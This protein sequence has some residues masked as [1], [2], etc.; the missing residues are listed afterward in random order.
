MFLYQTLIRLCGDYSTPF[1][2]LASPSILRLFDLIHNTSIR[3]IASGEFRTS[4]ISSIYTEVVK[5]FFYIRRIFSISGFFY[6]QCS[7]SRTLSLK[8]SISHLTS[9]VPNYIQIPLFSNNSQYITKSFSLISSLFNQTPSNKLPTRNI[10]TNVT[11]L[12]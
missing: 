12:L 9:F 1:Y 5:S 2:N 11:F 6:Q 8:F 7:Y 3:I 10:S 4:F